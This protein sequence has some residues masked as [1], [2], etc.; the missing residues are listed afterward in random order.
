MDNTAPPVQTQPA[1]QPTMNLFVPPESKGPQGSGDF[2]S[3]LFDCDG[4]AFC[5][6]YCCPCIVFGRNRERYDA[7]AQGTPLKPGQ[8]EDFGTSTLVFL[9]VHCFTGVGSVFLELIQRGAV[10]NRYGINGSVGEDALLSCCCMPC[11]QQQQARELHSEEAGTFPAV[12]PSHV[13]TDYKPQGS[14]A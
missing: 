9:A 5:L 8:V 12:G 2:T 7:L 3:G 13:S 14:P 4:G 11:S 6:S 1:A 10:R